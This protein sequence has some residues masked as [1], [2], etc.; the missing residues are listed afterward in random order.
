MF[1]FGIGAMT[2]YLSLKPVF[3]DPTAA[4]FEG[5]EASSDRILRIVSPFLLVTKIRYMLRLLA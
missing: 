5:N 2:G 4:V 3:G 1:T